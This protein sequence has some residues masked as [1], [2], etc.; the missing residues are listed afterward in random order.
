M[1]NQLP[2]SL[3]YPI[4]RCLFFCGFH[5]AAAD[6]EI[7]AVGIFH[8]EAVLGVDPRL[9]AAAPELRFD[10]LLIPVV[11][12]DRDVVDARRRRPLT[13]VARDDERVAEHELALVVALAGD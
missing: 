9:E 12:R 6:L 13:R 10:R 5:R 11:D 3:N 2:D 4:T 8:M 1:P 7:E